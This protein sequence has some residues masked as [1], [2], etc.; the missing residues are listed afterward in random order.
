MK[1]LTK[2]TDFEPIE[3]LKREMDRIFDDLVPFSWRMG[4]GGSKMDIWAPNTDIHETEKDYKIA[5]DLPGIPKDDVEI[6]FKDNRLTIT[7]ERVKEEKEEEKDYLRRERYH[8][9]FHRTFTFPADVKEDKIKA[10]FKEGVL[11]V[12]V[13]KTEAKKPKN[14]AID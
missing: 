2:R 3:D 14:I 4:N 1:T 13:P 8:G 6:N 9:R 11:T 7:G 10:S 12:T 5:I